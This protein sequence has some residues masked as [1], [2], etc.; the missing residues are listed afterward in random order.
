MTT[1]AHSLALKG[2]TPNPKGK[3]IVRMAQVD[4]GREEDA[5]SSGGK[6]LIVKVQA[7]R[8]WDG[9]NIQGNGGKKRIMGVKREA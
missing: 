1:D 8:G 9:K 4:L 6:R 7:S 2:L 5:P 3:K